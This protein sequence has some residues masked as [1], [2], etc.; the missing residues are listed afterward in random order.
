M[1]SPGYAPAPQA[2][3]ATSP[4]GPPV[5][6]YGRSK[7]YTLSLL[8]ASSLVLG[9]SAGVLVLT[10]IDDTASDDA[11][12]WTFILSPIGIAAGL[13][14]FIWLLVHL[15]EKLDVYQ[16]GF[17]HRGKRAVRWEEIEAI[18]SRIYEVIGG[19]NSGTK[20]HVTL[21][22]QGGRKLKLTPSLDRWPMRAGTSRPRRSTG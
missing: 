18:T 17:V 4:L 11:Q 15:G 12:L 9:G 14:G 22:L 20:G 8:I 6:H 19:N 2:P 16:L 5:K 21:W 1:M 13:A 7:E 3:P 10:A